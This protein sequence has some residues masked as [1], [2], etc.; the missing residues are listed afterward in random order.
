MSA[1]MST[2]ATASMPAP[3]PAL[4]EAAG[5]RRAFRMPKGQE[6][7][8]AANDVSFRIA[9]GEVLGLVGESGSGK[10]TIAR[11]LVGLERADAGSLR[12]AGADRFAPA[13]GRAARLARARQAQMV[14]QDPY[15]SLDRRLSV[16]QALV[17]AMRLHGLADRAGARRRAGELLDRVR[18][19]AEQG[20]LRPHQLSG[21]QRQRVAI[22]RALAVSPTLLVLDEAV[23][24]LD[25][26]VQAQI[27]ELVDEIRR[28]EGIAVLFVS[29][30][31]AVVDEIADRVLVLYR[32]DV[33]EEGAASAVFR[34]PE[35]PYTRLLVSS[36]PGPGWDPHEVIARRRE[37]DAAR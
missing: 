10:S 13:R 31:L 25:V 4:V 34:A 23:S 5:L 20:G 33:V 32:G 29:H 17:A 26:S 37:F 30:D 24:A 7:V 3:V 6:P 19:T 12:I 21:G 1:S 11:M 27:L 22:A 14:F 16:Q 28:D 18:L 15:G 35:H 8:V 2:P 36:V 9:A